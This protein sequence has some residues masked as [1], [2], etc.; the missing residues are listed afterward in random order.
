MGAMPAAVG[1]DR[2]GAAFA[3]GAPVARISR[4]GVTRRAIVGN[5]LVGD[6]V[7]ARQQV[8]R[9]IGMWPNAGVDHRD[10]HAR[11][12]TLVPGLRSPDAGGSV[13]VMPLRADLRIVGHDLGL[14]QAV[15]LDVLDIGV[16][17]AQVLGQPTQL[18]DLHAAIGLHHMATVGMA[19]HPLQQQTGAV[20][21]HAQS[22]TGAQ[23]QVLAVLGAAV[24]DDQAVG[25]VVIVGSRTRRRTL[26]RARRIAGLIGLCRQRLQ[27][28]DDHRHDQTQAL[29]RCTEAL[30][31][32][33]GL[34]GHGGL[35]AALNGTL[36]QLLRSTTPCSWSASRSVAVITPNRAHLEAIDPRLRHA[37]RVQIKLH[38]P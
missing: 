24:L 33:A 16:A 34:C 19:A 15:R 4:V 6:E 20:A 38:T 18:G 25:L 7:I 28:H 13:G 30:D 36:S 32:C 10:A 12:G 23:A 37:F 14:E 22:V 21:R 29:E 11:A 5:D 1:G 3:G 35:L 31:G 26:A 17:V 9:Q 27:G 8:G 2:A